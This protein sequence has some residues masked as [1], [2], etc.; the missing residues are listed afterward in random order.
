LKIRDKTAA[1]KKKK[2]CQLLYNFP[3]G[4]QMTGEKKGKYFPG[5]FK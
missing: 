2:F 1:L 3:N 4:K 5:P